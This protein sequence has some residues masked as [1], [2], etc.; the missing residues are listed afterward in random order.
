MLITLSI[1]QSLIGL[2]IGQDEYTIMF[3]NFSDRMWCEINND[4]TGETLFEGQVTNYEELK[5]FTTE[6][7][8]LNNFDLGRTIGL[9]TL[10]IMKSESTTPKN[11]F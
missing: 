11:I 8:I 10:R 6:F 5:E 7:D 1:I 2:Q 4:E 9:I 3:Y